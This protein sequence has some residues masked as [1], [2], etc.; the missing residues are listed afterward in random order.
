MTLLTRSTLLVV[1]WSCGEPKMSE[2]PRGFCPARSA[3]LAAWRGA[4]AAP[5]GAAPRW[6]G[7]TIGRRW[8]SDGRGA[9]AHDKG[10]AGRARVRQRSRREPRAWL[11]LLP[12]EDKA[13]G[14]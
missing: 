8:S 10:A 3:R 1:L 11:M 2:A 14:P 6:R 4:P 9:A 5:G 7:C 13:P 12:R